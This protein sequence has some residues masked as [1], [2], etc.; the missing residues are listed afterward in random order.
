VNITLIVPCFNEAL[1]LDPKYYEDLLTQTEVSLVFINDGS[2]DNTLNLLTAL[3]NRNPGRIILV[4]LQNNLGKANAIREGMLL[5]HNSLDK[6]PDFLGYL[7][8]DCA[9]GISDIKKLFEISTNKKIGEYDVISMA[10]IDLAGRSVQRKRYRQIIGRILGIFL[11]LTLPNFKMY[12]TQTGLKIFRCQS[13]LFQALDN[14][15]ETRW[16]IDLEI[17][18][19]LQQTKPNLLIWEEPCDKWQDIDNSKIEG[20]Q[21]FQ[22]IRDMLILFTLVINI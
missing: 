15:F 21:V 5:F 11:R 2:T 19:R 16:F 13:S 4:S 1:R 6:N 7:D 17:I 10:R 12:D 14:Q 3:K 9:F 18:L 8:A 22:V 20:K